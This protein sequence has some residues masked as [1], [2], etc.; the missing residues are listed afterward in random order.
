MS[1]YPPER[2]KNLENHNNKTNLPLTKKQK[3]K[4]LGKNKWQEIVHL[5][6][7]R[8]LLKHSKLQLIQRILAVLLMAM[9][10]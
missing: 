1:L 10:D 6:V 4:K 3:K 9:F 8:E 2:T 5:R 7:A